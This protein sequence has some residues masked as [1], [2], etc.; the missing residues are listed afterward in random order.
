MQNSVLSRLLPA[1]SL[2]S[3]PILNLLVQGVN[4]S[5][6]SGA[7]NGLSPTSF[8][9]NPLFQSLIRDNAELNLLKE[10]FKKYGFALRF[11]GGPVRDI[12]QGR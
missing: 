12:L 11:A 5:S 1:Q 6:P 8:A 2:L 10:M 9:S 3:R 4:M 7:N